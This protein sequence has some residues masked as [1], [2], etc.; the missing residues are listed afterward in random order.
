MPKNLDG[1]SL[2][3]CSQGWAKGPSCSKE[4]Q[5][6]HSPDVKT[7]CLTYVIGHICQIANPLANSCGCFGFCILICSVMKVNWYVSF[8]FNFSHSGEDAR[9]ELE[10]YQVIYCFVYFTTNNLINFMDRH[11]YSGIEQ[12]V[13]S[14]AW[15]SDQTGRTSSQ[16]VK[17]D[18]PPTSYRTYFPQSIMKQAVSFLVDICIV[19]MFSTGKIRSAQP[20]SP[21]SSERVRDTRASASGQKRRNNQ[22][23]PTVR[24]N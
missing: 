2:P 11:L 16:R 6:G 9:L 15:S 10:E 22:A 8:T 21:H 5:L 7:K 17:I 18:Q 24:T 20:R 1:C 12:R 19:S 14:R 4:G 23:N 13:R 3:I